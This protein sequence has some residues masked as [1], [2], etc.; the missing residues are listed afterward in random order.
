[1]NQQERDLI[2]QK[3][4]FLVAS[5][6]SCKRLQV[7]AVISSEGR[8]IS[9]G[10]NKSPLGECHHSIGC[11]PEVPCGTTHAEANAI[12]FAAKRGIA[13]VETTL[14]CTHQPCYDCAKLIIGAGIRR[15][16]Y[17]EAYRLTQG[18]ELLS[19]KGIIVNQVKVNE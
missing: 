6:A 4:A 11:N 19:N 16:V 8:I 9:S 12:A 5:S 17:T 3:V 15:V 1:M 2:N 18:L 13:L 10:F 7:G 14:H